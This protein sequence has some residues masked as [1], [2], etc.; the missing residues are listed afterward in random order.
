MRIAGAL[1]SSA[2]LGPES[3]AAASSFAGRPSQRSKPTLD[4]TRSHRITVRD[5]RV[6]L[7]RSLES[8]DEP[9]RF[10]LHAGSRDRRNPIRRSVAPLEWRESDRVEPASLLVASTLRGARRASTSSREV[11]SLVPLLDGWRHGRAG[12]RS[13]LR[14]SGGR[15][16]PLA[17]A[18]VWPELRDHDGTDCRVEGAY[19]C[20]GGT[21]W[22][23]WCGRRSLSASI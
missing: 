8:G 1:E 19:P 9:W 15:Q 16:S 21:F 3:C 11:V 2:F 10:V 4:S 18:F 12:P 20:G 5:D 7:A 14:G 22:L 17:G 23:P 13:V 6:E